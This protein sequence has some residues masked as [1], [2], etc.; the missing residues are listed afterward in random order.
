MFHNILFKCN[1]YK[2][3]LN[4]AGD[5]NPGFKINKTN[6]LF[7]SK[8]YPHVNGIIGKSGIALGINSC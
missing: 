2:Q 5:F 3:Q 1:C 8:S 4:K 7:N 6:F